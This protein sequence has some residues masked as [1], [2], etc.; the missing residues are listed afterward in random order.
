MNINT[1]NNTEVILWMLVME[2]EIAEETGITPT[3]R[4]LCR[5]YNE[6]RCL[7]NCDDVSIIELGKENHE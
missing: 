5:I 1:K 3:I 6:A 4:Q 7:K 2:K